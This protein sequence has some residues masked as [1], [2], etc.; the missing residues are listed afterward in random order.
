MVSACSPA[1]MFNPRWLSWCGVRL[2]LTNRMR[3]FITVDGAQQSNSICN[4]AM[5]DSCVL[6]SLIC[7]S[8]SHAWSTQGVHTLC[9]LGRSV[10]RMECLMAMAQTCADANDDRHT[11]HARVIINPRMPLL[12][13]HNFRLAPEYTSHTRARVFVE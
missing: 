2:A 5:T 7:I 10:Y 1:H 6:H 11:N 9:E 13:S 8:D 4:H 3:A 12:I